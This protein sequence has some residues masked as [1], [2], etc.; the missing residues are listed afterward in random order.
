MFPRNLWHVDEDGNMHRDEPIN[1]ALLVYM[2]YPNL[3]ENESFPAGYYRSCGNTDWYTLI[4]GRF[5][6]GVLKEHCSARDQLAIG[7][8]N[9]E[10][11]I[12][13]AFYIQFSF[14]HVF[15]IGGPLIRLVLIIFG[16]VNFIIMRR[17]QRKLALEGNG[18]APL[19]LHQI[20]IASDF[21][22]L[23]LMDIP[24]N[25]VSE[26]LYIAITGK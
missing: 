9:N 26:A 3:M 5:E 10:C 14:Y 8:W 6:Y 19:L 21:L 16:T 17:V 15:L 25:Q 13:L 20:Q 11:F 24:V 22:P 2:D 7:K 4:S 1:A 12:Y 18:G 23:L